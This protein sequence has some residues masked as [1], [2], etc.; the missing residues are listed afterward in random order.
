MAE[1]ILSNFPPVCRDCGHELDSIEQ[2]RFTGDPVTL[3]TCWEP[4]CLLHSVTL[5]EGQYNRLSEVDL[6]AY[7]VV[8]RAKLA[9]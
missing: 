3:L 9:V 1:W 2:P 5:S 8:N 4:G 7:R 6:E